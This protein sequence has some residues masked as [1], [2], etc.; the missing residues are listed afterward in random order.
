MSRRMIWT[1]AALATLRQHYSTMPS[2]DIA[3][4]I[5]CSDVAVRNKAHQLG[6]VKSEDFSAV[7]YVGRYSGKRKYKRDKNL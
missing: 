4:M 6:L 3:D 7:S 1:D 2:C 5:G